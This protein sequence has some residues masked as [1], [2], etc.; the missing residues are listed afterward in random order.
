MR[1][2]THMLV[3]LALLGGTLTGSRAA[4]KEPKRVVDPT[5]ILGSKAR[6][7][8]LKQALEKHLSGTLLAEL[9][10]NKR[11]YRALTPEQR[12]ALRQRVY[13]IFKMDP[14]R[15]AKIIEAGR[16][17]LNLPPEQKKKYQQRLVWLEKV[18]AK[19]TPQ[20]R[21]ALKRMTPAERAKRLLELKAKLLGA[22]PTSGPAATTAP[23]R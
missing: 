15:Q 10:R 3:I 11:D 23:A 20:Q 9:N 21:E 18:V 7:L 1:N 8:L 4:A 6:Q 19:L 5:K 14:E 17:F 12:R 13:A 22:H 2:W 16:E